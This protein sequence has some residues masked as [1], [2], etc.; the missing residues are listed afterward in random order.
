MELQT[1]FSRESAAEPVFYMKQMSQHR[2]LL[3]KN[4]TIA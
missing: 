3:P 1:F 4:E 2:L